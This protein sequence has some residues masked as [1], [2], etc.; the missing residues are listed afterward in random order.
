ML[1]YEIVKSTLSVPTCKESKMLYSFLPEFGKII[2][3]QNTRTDL[4]H[5]EMETTGKKEKKRVKYK[6]SLREL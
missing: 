5:V 6:E 1:N 3:E 4:F 2:L